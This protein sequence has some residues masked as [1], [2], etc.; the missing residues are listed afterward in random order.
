[1][2]DDLDTFLTTVYCL[3]DDCYRTE[4]LPY[5]PRRPGHRPELSDS[6]VLTLMLLAQWRLDR[7]LRALLRYAQRHWRGYFPR[8]LSQSAFQRRVHD[9][10]GALCRLGPALAEQ[11]QAQLGRPVYEVLDGV[12][13]P[14]MRRCRGQRHR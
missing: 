10:A 8:L 14:L 9:L 13:V 7:S 1:M 6:E 3:V 12:P 11:A 2:D 5:K 4:L